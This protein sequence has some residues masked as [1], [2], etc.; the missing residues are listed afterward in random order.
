[1]FGS[2]ATFFSANFL[3]TLSIFFL[4]SWSLLISCDKICGCRIL[5]GHFI[6]CY[7]QELFPSLFRGCFLVKCAV[8]LLYLNIGKFLLVPFELY[9]LD[10]QVKRNIELRRVY[11]FD[12]DWSFLSSC[13]ALASYSPH[14]RRQNRIRSHRI[15]PNNQC[16]IPSRLHRLPR[17]LHR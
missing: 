6:H 11:E 14:R 10:T 4:P 3:V 8:I 7:S 17:T 16:Q 9:F 12:E 1:M 13:G 2:C 5:P 15:H